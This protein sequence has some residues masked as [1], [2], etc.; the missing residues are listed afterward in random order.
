MTKSIK[1]RLYLALLLAL[2]GWA[3]WVPQVAQAHAELVKS[4]P[5]V[6][7][8]LAQSPPHHHA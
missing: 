4:S 8:T 2:M 7:E 6:G 1:T 3:A 5:E